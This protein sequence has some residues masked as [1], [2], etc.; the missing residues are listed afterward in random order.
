[1]SS[2]LDEGGLVSHTWAKRRASDLDGAAR[3]PAQQPGL[4]FAF[5]RQELCGRHC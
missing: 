3:C 4:V 2:Q 1:M 5:H